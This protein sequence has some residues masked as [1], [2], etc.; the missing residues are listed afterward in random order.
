MSIHLH[1]EMENLNRAALA[2]FAHVEQSVRDAVRAILERDPESAQRVIQADRIIDKMESDLTENC[3]KTMA[4]HQPV[5]GDLR[6]IFSLSKICWIIDRTSDLAV[7]LAHKGMSL[8]GMEP[9]ALPGELPEMAGLA[10]A[11]LR[12][13][14][15][16]FIARDAAKAYAVIASDGEV[17]ARKRLA[18]AAGEAAIMAD[19]AVCPQWL[20]V[21]AASRNIE[22]MADMA[23]NIATE[24]V[25]SVDGKV[26]R[27]S[28]DD[29]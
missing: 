21:I 14:I 27:H 1:R 24:V 29:E 28:F 18:R 12:S 15:D 3:L 4:L 13:G 8:A 20:V 6:F 7:N 2:M 5:A 25:Y 11:M 23:A 16:S 19:P 26:A 10:R 17:N 9:I 22:R